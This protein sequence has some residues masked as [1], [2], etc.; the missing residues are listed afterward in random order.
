MKTRFAAL[1]QLKSICIDQKSLSTEQLNDAEDPALAKAIC[2]GVCRFY[3]QLGALAEQLLAKPFKEKDLDVLL[4]LKIGLFQLG[5]MS[6]KAHAAVNET[7]ELCDKIKKSWAKGVI[8]ACLHRFLDDKDALLQ[9]TEN[10]F[11]P[12]WLTK[13]LK[14]AYPDQWREI[15]QENL[16]QAPMFIRINPSHCELKGRGNLDSINNED[17]FAI[18]RDDINSSLRDPKGRSNL[19]LPSEAKKLNEPVAPE[20]IPSFD[21]G[22]CY[23]Q[24]LSPQFAP[25]L[26]DLA[27]N[28]K[29]LDACA[30][31]G[32]KSL[33]L[34]EVEPTIDLLCL[35]HDAK[36]L[37]RLHENFA[38]FGKK[39]NAVAADASD[40]ASWFDDKPFDRIL[41]DAPCSATGVIRR[42]PDINLLR[43][44]SD[45][46]EL[47]QT[48]LSILNAL[49]T[50]LK[51]GGILLYATCSV[52]PQENDETISAF[53]SETPTAKIAEF[54]LPIGHATKH[55]WQIL[56][57][58][59][60][61]D[62]FF[63]AKLSK[64]E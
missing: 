31:P 9:K 57:G 58:D 50:T 42:H 49:F 16:K 38:R 25:H 63:Y 43:R 3:F 34:L 53:L 17:H 36:R 14:K 46:A 27:A 44:E 56:P 23:I 60:D 32:G 7:V 22:S 28:Q 33:H 45:I 24:D 2:F 21:K 37:V 61:A 11:G 41:L 18:A 1:Q 10:C 4:I 39:A 13:M 64:H 30:A 54:T 20:K 29:V 47:H 5:F 15:C 40:L 55:G 26:L 62:G 19:H 59:G 52:L 48:Q 12:F 6:T 8:N 35:D 51:P